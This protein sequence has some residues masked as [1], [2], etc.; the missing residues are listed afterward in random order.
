[1]N[2]NLNKKVIIVTGG[3]SGMGERICKKLAEEGAIPCILDKN[4]KNMRKVVSEIKKKYAIAAF[5]V[6]TELTDPSSC[7]Y[8]INKILFKFERID[9]LVNNIGTNDAVSLENGNYELFI[10]TINKNARGYFFVSL[11]VLP[12]LKKSLGSIVNIFSK[13]AIADKGEP[14]GYASANGAKTAT[15]EWG[16]ELRPFGINVNA[17]VVAQC[18]T[19]PYQSRINQD[20]DPVETLKISSILPIITPDEVADAVVVLL[21]PNSKCLNGQLFFWDGCLS[22]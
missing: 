1:M 5:S 15:E 21:S 18:S 9:G 11:Y 14:W 3:A 22:L 13:A 17:V 7:Q 16:N 10:G 19:R 6:F 12:A 2:L 20:A 4:E 8:S